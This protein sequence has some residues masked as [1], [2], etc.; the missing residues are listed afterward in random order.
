MFPHIVAG[1]ISSDDAEWLKNSGLPFFDVMLL[2]NLPKSA[3]LPVGTLNE[4]KRRMQYGLSSD[5]HR[6]QSWKQFNYLYFTESDQILMLRISKE[7]FDQ[8]DKY[9]RRMLLPHRLMP[10]PD[11]VLTV[12]HK[13]KIDREWQ[14]QNKYGDWLEQS[15]CI[16]RQNCLSRSKYVTV[17]LCFA[18]WM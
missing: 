12:I 5:I 9:P 17:Y 8:I 2:K 16:M 11:N 7:L 15:C 4:A 10:Y 1:V 13:R 6:D 18:N 14:R 3:A